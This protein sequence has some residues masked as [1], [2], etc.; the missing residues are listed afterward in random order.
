MPIPCLKTNA[1]QCVGI[2]G[3]FAGNA[4]E[5]LVKAGAAKIITCNTISHFSNQ[6]D[7]SIAIVE[8]LRLHL[9]VKK[10]KWHS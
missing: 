3:L 8:K 1:P 2:H 10:D 7:V 6:I 9:S 4:Y 5:N